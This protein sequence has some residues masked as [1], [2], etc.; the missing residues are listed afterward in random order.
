MR[1]VLFIVYFLLSVTVQAQLL[2]F[3]QHGKSWGTIKGK[4][5]ASGEDYN[6][7][8]FI[9]SHGFLPLGSY[10]RVTNL[11]SGKSTLVQIVDRLPEKSN[12]VILLSKVVANYLDLPRLRAGKVK[13]ELV[14]PEE[15]LQDTRSKHLAPKKAIPNSTRETEN[16]KP[17]IKRVNRQFHLHPLA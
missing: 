11:K 4:T 9:A 10:V 14:T 3:E 13:I 5:T 1:W 16:K 6:P 17:I 15:M 7:G 2:G 12:S 8:N